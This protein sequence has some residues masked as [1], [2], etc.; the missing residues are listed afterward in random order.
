MISF[1]SD[2]FSL[3][4]NLCIFSVLLSFSTLLNVRLAVVDDSKDSF[5]LFTPLYAFFVVES[6]FIITSTLVVL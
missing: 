2:F 4:A 5:S 1:Y 6:N 3:F